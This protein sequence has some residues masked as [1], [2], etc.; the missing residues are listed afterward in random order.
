MDDTAFDALLNA[1]APSLIARDAELLAALDEL[2]EV[3]TQPARRRRKLQHSVAAG[4][5]VFGTLGL[6]GVAAA[7]GWLPYAWSPWSDRAFDSGQACQLRFMA[8]EQLEPARAEGISRTE[9]REAI[10]AAQA[11]LDTFN[12]ASIDQQAALESLLA[13]QA[14]VNVNIPEWDR[15]PETQEQLEVH[16][17]INAT[18]TQLS[19]ALEQQDLNPDAVS[20]ITTTECG[21]QQ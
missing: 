14:R 18:Y 1:S 17:L 20:I 13:E 10:V 8:T 11:F 9:Q 19:V 6:G 5:I 3:T 4:L 2:V 21:D 7:G 15:A 12:P 16:A